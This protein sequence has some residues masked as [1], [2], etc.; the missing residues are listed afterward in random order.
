MDQPKIFFDYFRS[1]NGNFHFKL[2]YPELNG[3]N[4]WTQTNNP[5]TQDVVTGFIGITT[6]VLLYLVWIFLVQIIWTISTHILS[7]KQV[8]ISAPTHRKVCKRRQKSTK[9]WKIVPT[10]S[11]VWRSEQK[12]KIVHKRM[13]KFALVY[14]LTWKWVNKVKSGQM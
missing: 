14:K 2:V 13:Q 6:Y 10:H 4:E 5:T 1:C 11:K 8:Q 7:G 3:Y 12:H 9:T